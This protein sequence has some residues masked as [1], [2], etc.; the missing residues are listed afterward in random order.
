MQSRI[1]TAVQ[2]FSESYNCAQAVFTTYGPLFDVKETDALRIATG[3]GGGMGHLQE[4]CDAVTGAFLVIGC[5]FGMRQP[6]DKAA[7]DR[8]YDLVHELGKR[9]AALHGT[10]LCRSLLG[11]DLNTTEG[12]A[13]FKEQ[14]LRDTK[15]SVYVRDVSRLLEE[16]LSV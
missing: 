1:E 16:M 8:T 6:S 5:C 12:K 9:F 11:C 7:K 4:V 3:F 2:R 13:Q 14:K 10:L 15:C